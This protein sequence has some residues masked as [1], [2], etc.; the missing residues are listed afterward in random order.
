MENDSSIGRSAEFNTAISPM[1]D[2][3][4]LHTAHVSIKSLTTERDEANQ[5]VTVMSSE[6]QDLKQELSTLKSEKDNLASS[7][8]GYTTRILLLETEK[9][10]ITAKSN[11]LEGTICEL[12]KQC[13]HLSNE[14]NASKTKFNELVSEV[15]ANNKTLESNHKE[16]L[17]QKDED[18]AFYKDLC[19]QLTTKVSQ[20]RAK[21][22]LVKNVLR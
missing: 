20:Q 18:L 2:K 4:Q 8:V 16:S 7:I 22:K 10:D 1:Q 9:A 11:S 5:R 14:T 19:E 21:I 17:E 6:N 3:A 15:N 12:Q 13:D